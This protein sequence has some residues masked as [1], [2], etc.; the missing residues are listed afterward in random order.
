[1]HA[2]ALT[3]LHKYVILLVSFCEWRKVAVASGVPRL[4]TVMLAG[5]EYYYCE[6]HS[7]QFKA[8]AAKVKGVSWNVFDS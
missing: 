3:V 4:P 2:C 8:D 7:I 5:E 1:M 6:V